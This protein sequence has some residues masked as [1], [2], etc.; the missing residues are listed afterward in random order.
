MQQNSGRFMGVRVGIGAW[1][2]IAVAVSNRYL[3]KAFGQDEGGE[4]FDE[5]DEGTLDDAAALQTGHSTHVAGMIYARELEQGLFGTAKRR[6]AFR[7]VSRQWH[8]FLG[9]GVEDRGVGAVGRK[10]KKEVFDSMRE[11]ARYRRFERLRQVD[12]GGRLRQMV[13]PE[14]QFRGMQETVIRAIIRG[15]SPIIQVAGTGGGKSMSFMLPAF[16]SPHGVTIVVVP[17]VALQQDLH[18]RCEEAKIDVHVWQSRGGNRGT[19]IVFVTLESVVTKGFRLFANRLQAR[20]QL[21]R[22]VVDECHTVLDSTRTFRPQMGQLG[23]AIWGFGV[24]V[25]FL[26]A[27]LAPGDVTDFNTRMKLDGQRIVLF[28]DRTRRVNVG[29]RVRVVE[30]V[31]E[32]DEEVRRVVQEMLEKYDSGRVIV[33]GGEISRVERLGSLLS[34]PVFYNK[35]DTREGKER[36]MRE[37]AE[38]SGEARVIITTNALGL[39]IDVPDVRSVVHVGT[40][41]RLRDYAQESGRAGRDGGQSEAVIVHT[42][43]VGQGSTGGGEGESWLDGGMLEFI[44]GMGCRRVVLDRVMDG[45]TQ[46]VGCKEGEE[47]CDV[48]TRGRGAES[49][50]EEEGE[51]LGLFLSAEA[52]ARVA[53]QQQEAETRQQGEDADEFAQ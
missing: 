8:R 6:D 50:D 18:R 34:Y 41:R 31:E 52:G 2:Q 3:N 14:A 23:E 47:E 51:G 22:V 32:A 16:C 26:T 25:V 29:Y 44:S 9:F 49:S 27:T 24:Q 21:D 30:G 12:I 17:L 42:G 48:C 39:G 46:R 4:D 40:P 37:W 15:E 10:R 5:D 38:G 13:G 35:V 36:R 43:Q 28:R 53:Q 33:Y 11:E 45:W 20:G 7:V 19:S 1:R